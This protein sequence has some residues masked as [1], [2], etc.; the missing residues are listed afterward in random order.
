M[1]P[2]QAHRCAATRRAH[3]LTIHLVRQ[4]RVLLHLSFRFVELIDVKRLVSDNH[5]TL[6][7]SGFVSFLIDREK[8]LRTDFEM[9]V[10]LGR[11]A[12]AKRLL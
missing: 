9:P 1:P 2:Q 3:W 7:V 12:E 6:T 10:K 8:A 5:C 11:S 4:L